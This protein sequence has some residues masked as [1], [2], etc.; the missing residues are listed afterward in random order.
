MW[1]E[2]VG[3]VYLDEG[4]EFDDGQRDRLEQLGWTTPELFGPGR[5]NYWREYETGHF[6]EAASSVALTFVEVFDA[7]PHESVYVAVFEALA[8]SG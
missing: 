2:S 5:G 7:L 3:D 4:D 6:L 1:A 8:L